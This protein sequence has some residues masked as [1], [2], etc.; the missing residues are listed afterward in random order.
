MDGVYI[1][2]RCVFRSTLE[3]DYTGF[4]SVKCT[5]GVGRVIIY[6]A[7]DYVWQVLGFQSNED[8]LPATCTWV[9]FSYIYQGQ[10]GYIP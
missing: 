10:T 8:M 3:S 7:K 2:V 6:M 5:Y 9:N 4:P 1:I